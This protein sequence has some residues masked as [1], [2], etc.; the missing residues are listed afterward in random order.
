MILIGKESMDVFFQRVI[1]LK[2]PCSYHLF[3]LFQFL[4]TLP[5]AV[6]LNLSFQNP[7]TYSSSSVSV[8]LVITNCEVAVSNTLRVFGNNFL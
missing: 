6:V 4:Q 2:A 7:E 1:P 8:V 3:I 5:F